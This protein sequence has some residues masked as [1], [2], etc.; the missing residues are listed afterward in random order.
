MPMEKMLILAVSRALLTGRRR[1]ELKYST[2]VESLRYRCCGERIR[3][4]VYSS[5]ITAISV[6]HQGGR[7]QVISQQ[8]QH[9]DRLSLDR[10]DFAWASSCVA[11]QYES[12]GS[13]V[14]EQ[15][16]V[17]KQCERHDKEYEC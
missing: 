6:T 10:G 17:R 1:K 3:T 9:S 4:Y 13:H 12:Y 11:K 8:R 14:K 15:A 2:N 5:S 16:P 7:V